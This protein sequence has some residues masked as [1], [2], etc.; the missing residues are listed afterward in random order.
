MGKT[1]KKTADTIHKSREPHTLPCKLDAEG[2]AAAAGKL[3]KANQAM[4]SLEAE[5]K[6]T[7]SGFTAR[8]NAL[9]S[10]VHTLSQQVTDGV[11]MQNVECELQ[12]N[13]TTMRATLIRLDTQ[14]VVEERAMTDEEKQMDLPF[15]GDDPGEPENVF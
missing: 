5:K 6:A 8:K 11:V 9:L 7:M 10:E 2:I 15:D 4:E 13:Y 1:T 14:E 12:L 3:A